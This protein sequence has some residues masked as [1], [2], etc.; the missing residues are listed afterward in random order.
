MLPDC[1]S[2]LITMELLTDTDMLLIVEKGIHRY[3]IA[4]N[5]YKIIYDE[6]KESSYL[7]YLILYIF[8]SRQII[9]M[10]GQMSQTL[11]V[12]GFEW[13]KCHVYCDIGYVPEV[14][15]EYSKRLSQSFTIYRLKM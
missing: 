7:M 6:D 10:N 15:I 5:N 9:Y 4:D 14:D 2:V 3:E 13:K 1:L 8:S 11:L 12:D